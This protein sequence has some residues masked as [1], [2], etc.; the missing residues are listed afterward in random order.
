MLAFGNARIG[1]LLRRLVLVTGLL[2]P[3]AAAAANTLLV[4]GDSISAGYGLP[5]GASWVSLLGER[6]AKAAPDYRVVNASISGETLAGGKRRIEALLEQHKPSIVVI[7]LGANDGLRGASVEAMRADLAAIVDACLQRKAQVVLLGMRLPPN[8]GA[9]Y[10]QRFE[11]VYADIAQKRRLSFVPFLFEGFGERHEYFQP[12]GIHPT[13]AAQ[14]LMLESVWKPLA[15]L[16]TGRK[17]VQVR[18]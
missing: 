11:Q 12:D 13:R 14:P 9:A 3:L 17:H 4:F 10:V 5:Q 16:L 2:F 15:P 8:Y 7:E 6:M 1:L 18:Q